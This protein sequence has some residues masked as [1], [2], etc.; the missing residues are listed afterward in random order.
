M[1]AGGMVEMYC[2]GMT[3]RDIAEEAGVSHET[4]RKRLR[5]RGVDLRV[6]GPR[7]DHERNR[8]IVAAYRSGVDTDVLA[9]RFGLSRT[10]V[11]RIA[12]RAGVYRYYKPEP[13]MGRRAP[14]ESTP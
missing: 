11:T 3:L 10:W 9:E 14:K 7:I 6:A 12:N 1:D 13:A 5:Q 2:D 4:V 8:R